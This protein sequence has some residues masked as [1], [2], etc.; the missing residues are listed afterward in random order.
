MVEMSV[1]R[2]LMVECAIKIQTAK[3]V[4]VEV[5]VVKDQDVMMYCVMVMRQMKIAVVVVNRV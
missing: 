2:V 5:N 4:G 3:A 1:A